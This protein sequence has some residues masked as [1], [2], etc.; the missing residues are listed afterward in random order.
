MNATTL[1]K[2]MI[3]RLLKYSNV[4]NAKMDI[5]RLYQDV[6]IVK[7]DASLV[8]KVTLPLIKQVI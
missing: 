8:I 7:K 3:K 1:N 4:Q 5:Y 6:C 2:F